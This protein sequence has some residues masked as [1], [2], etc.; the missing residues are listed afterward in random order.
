MDQDGA[1]W[2]FSGGLSMCPNSFILPLK[3][4]YIPLRQ[5]WAISNGIL[6]EC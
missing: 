3:M 4:H 2:N 5:S 1:W 6:V